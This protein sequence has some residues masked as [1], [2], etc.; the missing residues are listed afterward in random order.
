MWWREAGTVV[1]Q[2]TFSRLLMVSASRG[3][4]AWSVSA[5]ASSRKL[6]PKCAD[7]QRCFGLRLS[8]AEPMGYYK[9][10]FSRCV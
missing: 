3:A 6:L 2:G 7:F 9:L 10:G 5:S 1:A 8:T 4:V